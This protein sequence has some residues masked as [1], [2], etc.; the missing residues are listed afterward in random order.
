MFIYFN[1]NKCAYHKGQLAP[2]FI[3]FIILIVIAALV[4]VNIGKV[5]KT[6]I[7][8]AN[9]VDAGALAAA[10]TMASAFN[11]IAV[12]NS[13]MR[14]NYQ[15]FFG[16]ASISFAWGYWKIGSAMSSASTAIAF[17]TA[18]CACVPCCGHACPCPCFFPNLAA[19]EAALAEA[20][21]SLVDFDKTMKSL[22][23]QVSSFYWLQ[24]EFYKVIRENID[25][26]HQSALESGYSFAFNNSGIS[27]RLKG[28]RLEDSSLCDA[29]ED[30]CQEDCK[31]RCG[32]RDDY[33]ID[34]KDLY[35]ECMDTC[36]REELNCLINNCQSHRAEYSLWLK[37]ELD[38]DDPVSS[39]K[40]INYN[41]LDG[42]ERSH[43]VSTQVVIDPVDEYV[44]KH[45]VLPFL[46]DIA[47][48]TTAMVTANQAKGILTNAAGQASSSSPCSAEVTAAGALSFNVAALVAS[49]AAHSGLATNG[50]FS[51]T[52]DSDAWP[53]IICWIDDVPHNQL[54][55]VYQT[56]RDQGAD[57][58]VWS[59]EYPLITSSSRASFAGEGAIYTPSP[60]YDATIILT[61]FLS[62]HLL[63]ILGEPIKDIE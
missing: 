49:I 47:L 18:A 33:L 16:L 3:V 53:Y 7:Y 58:G 12:A 60:N 10:S 41:W 17:L 31:G 29:C 5:A 13:Q 38:D 25:D 26:Y 59:T 45:T 15:Y 55:D 34:E 32:D 2:F 63:D 50:T 51:S 37:N 57:V 11:Y 6:K 14:V 9:S 22:I 21:A 1:E 43:D 23:V 4:T 8:S 30:D 52:S 19:G 40:I 62:S 61:D 44:L 54:V 56:Q 39:Q 36:S 27:S 28:C 42:Q 35:D 48:L 46:A 20:I 24:Y